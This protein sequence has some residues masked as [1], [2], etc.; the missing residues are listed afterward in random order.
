MRLAPLFFFLPTLALSQSPTPFDQLRFRTIGPAVMGGRMHDVEGVPND[1]SVL[2]V[3]AA[4]GGVWKSVNKGTTWTPVFDHQAVSTTGDIAIFGP[5]PDIV[6]LGT[7]EQNNR[8]SSSWGNGV[9]RTTDGGRTWTHLGLEGTHMIAKV[10]LHPSDPNV[11]YVAA[12][13]NLWKPTA[14]R[15]VYKTADGGRTWTRALF[16]DTLTGAT[17][18]VMD[19]GDP[20]TLYAAM[21]QRLRTP[22]GFNG[23]G[24][25]SGIYKTTDGGATWKPLTN[26]IPAGDKGRIGL[27]IAYTYPRM[28]LATIEAPGESG[29]Y[30]TED[31]G[32]TWTRLNSTN[33]RPMYYS[34][35]YIDPTNERRA[36]IL[37]VGV[38]RSDDG[39]RVFREL[40]N[41]PTY[42]VGL[43][44]DHH[45]LWINPADP[46]QVYLAGDGGLHESFDAG[47][48]WKR[49]NNIPVGQFYAIDADDRDPYWLYGGMQ[50]NH[51]WMGPSATRHWLGIV[52]TDWR[53]IGFGDG[54]EQQAD[55]FNGRWVYSSQQ[56]GNVFRV[57]VETGDRLPI[58]PQPPEGET[59]RWDWTAPILA[60]RQM[61]GTVYIGANRLFIS[62]DHGLS[63]TA[64]PDLTRQVNRDTIPIMGVMGSEIRITRNDGESS[65]SELTTISESPVD[66]RVIWVGADDGNLQV[67]QDAGATWTE[68]SRNVSG[69]PDGTFVS[70]VVGSAGGRGVAWAT[71]DGHRSGDFTPYVYRTT[72]FGRTWTRLTTGIAGGHAVRTIHE[73][74]GNAGVV[75]AGTEFA[76]YVSTDTARTWT[77]LAANLPTTRYDD[78]L[79]HPR[80]KDLILG[81]H[82]RSI[83][84]LDDASAI[85]GWT[86]PVASRAAHLFPVRPATLFQYWQD[87]S[88]WA[89]GEYLGENPPDGALLTY[90]LGRE[91]PSVTVTV[92]APNGRVVRELTG[93]GRAGVLHRVNWDLRHA[94]PSLDGFVMPASAIAAGGRGGRGGRGGGGGGGGGRGA[95]PAG[96]DEMGGGDAGGWGWTPPR[97]FGARGPYVAPGTYTVTL[98]AGGTKVS[99]T[100]RVLADPVLGLSVAQHREREAFLLEAIDMLKE[101]TAMSQQIATLRRDLTAR[102]DAAAEGSPARASADQALERLTAAE[103][104]FVAGPVMLRGRLTSLLSAFNGSGVQPGTLYPPSPPQRAQAREARAA[105]DRVR[106][107]L[108]VLLP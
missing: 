26:G 76:L 49:V 102:R 23:G 96:G 75:F 43:K 58:R 89:Q 61:R 78:I 20:N 8:Q 35:I 16:V 54:M 10:R 73:Y 55:P 85:A 65:F 88:N 2:W 64:T 100:V 31:G 24:P 68:V 47:L 15:G 12:L 3:A 66:P 6:W 70:R 4:S 62:R 29:T 33:P 44:T 14:D 99:E 82:G 19:P 41:S 48:T 67:S 5:D 84:I 13:G 37:G 79:V 38:F 34:K 92:T 72:D 98:D 87:F 63:W 69:L 22:W 17:D 51:S 50:D 60:S 94:V 59:Y 46:K 105:L 1:P 103:R 106:R 56:N 40:P 97:S 28:L 39:G 42:D 18:I 27:A 108:A 30:R 95:A 80:T 57:D 104:S 45:A 81:T 52:N 93:P 71:F 11:A 91:V 90:T 86:R 101:T 77:R 107:E 83:W 32:E 53:Q 7:G 21:Y 9:Y 36:W 25:G 74:P